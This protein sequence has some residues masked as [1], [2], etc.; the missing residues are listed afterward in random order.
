MK[1]SKEGVGFA[2]QGI[3]TEQFA[4]FEENFQESQKAT[5]TTSIQFGLNPADFIIVVFFHIEFRQSENVLLK[6]VLSSHFK[7]E[8]TNWKEFEN[9][10][11]TKIIVSKGILAHIS[12]ISASTARGVLFAKTEGTPLSRFI[13]PLI[14]VAVM[15]PEDAVF[16]KT[17][18]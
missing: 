17:K 15:I 8:K 10:E 6:L 16:E 1:E 18:I 11:E 13:V 4:I 12:A 5:M 7:V 2:L 9:N 14:N 3:K